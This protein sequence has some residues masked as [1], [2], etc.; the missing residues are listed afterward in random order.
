MNQRANRRRAFHRVRQPNVQG[1]LAGLPDSAGKNEEG[2]RSADSHAADR[3]AGH[4]PGQ[5]GL[6]QAAVAVVIKEQRA[7]L[8]IEPE[9]SEQESDV[10]H[11]RG[12]DRFFCRGGGGGFL[13]PETNE[14]IGRQPHQFPADEQQKQAVGDDDAQHG[15]RKKRQEAEEPREILIVGHVP[16][17]VDKNPEPDERDHHRHPLCQWVEDEPE[18]EARGPELEPC[19]VED[20]PLDL[21]VLA[22][23]ANGCEECPERENTREAHRD[24]GQRSRRFARRAFHQ[25]LNRRGHQWEKRDQPLLPCEMLKVFAVFHLTPSGS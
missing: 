17:R 20:R 7:A 5:R 25:R 24:D 18:A 14:Q 15:G 22:A 9:H 16:R 19:K 21:V 12:D 6:F 13:K 23:T 3:R 2:D 4:Q 1:H 10:A 11:A 8:G